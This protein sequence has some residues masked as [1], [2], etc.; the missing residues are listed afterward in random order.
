MVLTSSKVQADVCIIGS[1]IVG[2]FIA[3]GLSRLGL[4]CVLLEQRFPGSGSSLHC[5]GVLH[6]GA[7]YA[8]SEPDL[9]RLCFEASQ[10]IQ[11]DYP[12]AVDTSKQ[13]YYVG[14]MPSHFD[15]SQRLLEICAHYGCFMQYVD[16]EKLLAEEPNLN[17]SIK[18]GIEVPDYVIDPAKLI[19][20]CLHNINQSGTFVICETEIS[21]IERKLNSW[22]L[23]TY[24]FGQERK[25][26]TTGLVITAGS[27][28]LHLL[29][30][31][32]NIRVPVQY[33]N[34]SMVVLSKRLLN[35]IISLCDMSSS[36]DSAIPCYNNTLLG[37]TWRYQDTFTPTEISGIEFDEISQ[38]A[39]TLLSN[40]IFNYVSHSYSGV[41]VILPETRS[42]KRLPDRFTKRGYYILDCKESY[43][44][45]VL[46]AAFG[47]KMTLFQNIATDTIRLL[48]KQMGLDYNCSIDFS[49]TPYPNEIITNLAS[50]DKTKLKTFVS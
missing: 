35:R 41:R 39:S 27:W 34:G 6:S 40:Q 18:F 25:I 20:S 3:L 5:G 23:L 30:R 32:F 28:S 49:L 24:S 11:K 16:S 33:I 15:Y 4:S 36:G 42:E 45:P 7:R 9:A 1:G 48:L 17:Q 47:G 26:K 31:F 46:V 43:G 19:V 29:R 37:S 12:F 50:H 10:V 8:V 44:L 2:L 13:A 22:N 38:K 14:F 21:S